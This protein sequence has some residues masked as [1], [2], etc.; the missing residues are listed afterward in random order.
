M[1]QW[2]GLAVAAAAACMVVR[3]QQPQMASVCATA[4]GIM[5]VLLAVQE[6]GEIQNL[7][8]RLT[9]LAGLQEGYLQTLLKAMGV[10]YASELAGQ[11]CTDLGENGLAAK[12]GLMG[13]LCIFT[14]TAPLMLTI[15]EMILELVP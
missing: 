1:W 9:T 14:L 11:V 2:L 7:F 13:K 6:L 5:L 12:V 3:L 8:D 10:S 4:A 15:L